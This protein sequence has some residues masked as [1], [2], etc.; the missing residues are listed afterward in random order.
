MEI[1][2]DCAKVRARLEPKYN[3]NPN[4]IDLAKKIFYSMLR[5]KCTDDPLWLKTAEQVYKETP[6]FGI[7]KNLAIKYLAQENYAKA[8]EWFKKALSIAPTS[9]DKAEMIMYLAKIEAKNGSKVAARDYCRQALSADP[10]LKEAY[11]LIG[12]LYMNSFKD[13]SKEKSYAE[14]RLVYIA[15][16]DMYARSG[17]QQKMGQAKSQFPSTTEIFEVGW[18]EGESKKIDWCWVGETIT[19]RTRGKD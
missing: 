13:C 9:G 1:P 7:A 6:D 18:K 4:D 5:G 2:F 10:G 19:I 12:D 15:A 8:E 14:D 16:Y 11:E 3:A 17:D